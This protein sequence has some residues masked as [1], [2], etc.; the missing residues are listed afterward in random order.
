MSRVLTPEQKAR[1]LEMQRIRRAKRTVEQKEEDKR[2]LQAYRESN[3]EK[4][5]ATQKCWVAENR[6]RKR[7]LVNARRKRVLRQSPPWAD[8]EK[9]TGY[10]RLAQLMSF[11]PNLKFH[12]DH[13]IPLKG[14]NVSGLHCE[15]NL[16]LLP[17]KENIRK[18]NHYGV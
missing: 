17:E 14:E 4:Y 12:V 2:K 15:S 10:Y 3:K 8:R 16:Q 13:V 6:D 1:K 5:A 18:S 11:S 7:A 9:L